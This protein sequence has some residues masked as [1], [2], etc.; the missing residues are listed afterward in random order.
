MYLQRA[1]RP[2]NLHKPSD[3]VYIASGGWDAGSQEAGKY[4]WQ[5]TITGAF[6]LPLT[7]DF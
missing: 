3:V 2:A 4:L 7:S 6:S 5:R 1:I